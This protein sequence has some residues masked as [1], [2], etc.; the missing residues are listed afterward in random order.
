MI[1]VQLCA[2]R[3]RVGEP[4]GGLCRGAVSAIV[5]ASKGGDLWRGVQIRCDVAWISPLTLQVIIFE[6]GSLGPFTL[7]WEGCVECGF[8]E[9]GGCSTVQGWW[10]ESAMLAWPSEVEAFGGMMR[11]RERI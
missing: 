7:G 8:A 10:F 6:L 5:G 11:V 1:V 3:S 2:G 9:V 4:I